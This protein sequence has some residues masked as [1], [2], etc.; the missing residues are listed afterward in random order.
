MNK[1]IL[2]RTSSENL[3]A[4]WSN[5]PDWTIESDHNISYIV[6]SSVVGINREG[7]G[8]YSLCKRVGVLVRKSEKIP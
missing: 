2:T 3:C 8:G 7:K 4:N 1:A 5:W 6:T